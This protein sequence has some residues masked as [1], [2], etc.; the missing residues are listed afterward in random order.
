MIAALEAAAGRLAPV[1]GGALLTRTRH[2]TELVSARDALKRFVNHDLSPE[3]SAEELRIAAHHLG[4]LTGHIG[5]E[6]V[7]GAI[8]AEFCI[9]KWRSPN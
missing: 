4:R 6:E 7:L 2:R 9:G 1:S 5:V 8:F 3:L